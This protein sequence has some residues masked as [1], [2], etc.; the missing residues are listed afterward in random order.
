MART[1]KTPA[2]STEEILEGEVTTTTPT[3]L[4]KELGT[5][6]KTFRR[7]LRSLTTD[8]AGKGGRW[9]IEAAEADAIRKA[10]AERSKPK[11][12]TLTTDEG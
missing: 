6:P 9:N 1:P 11:T 5:D 3:E 8:R 2:A 4:A 12:L 7:F 10:W